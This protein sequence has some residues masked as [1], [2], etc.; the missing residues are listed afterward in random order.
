MVFDLPGD[1]ESEILVRV[2]FKSPV[3][4]KTACKRWYTLFKDPKF[5]KKNQG[6]SAREVISLMRSR[7]YSLSINLHG[8][9]NG[10]DPSVELRGKLT[11]DLKVSE[12][13]HCDGLILCLTMGNIR[14]VVWNPCTG[15]IRWI[16][17]G[18]CYEPHKSYDMYVLGY[19]TSNSSCRSYKILRFYFCHEEFDV[20]ISEIKMYEFSSDSWKVL[21]VDTRNWNITSRGVSFRENAYWIAFDKETGFFLLDF[22]FT[23]ERFGRL[24]IPYESHD[25]GDSPVLSVVKDERLSMLHQDITSFSVVMKVW[26]TNKI[27]DTK[28]LSWSTFFVVD[29]DEFKIPWVMNVMSFLLDEENKVAV[30]CDTSTECGDHTNRADMERTRIYIVG[31]DIYKQVYTETSKGLLSDWPLLVS[32][33]PSLVPIQAKENETEGGRD[34]KPSS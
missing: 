11:E 2:P 21:D 31:E 32:Y 7:V 22:D 18:S 28:D 14:L 33:V 8:I 23:A 10:V 30:C 9:H 5:V 20:L 1:L 24:P 13:Y 27:V 4:F 15:E 16:K 25:P 17:P 34:G 19:G 26:V 3:K 29:L 12:M 6:K